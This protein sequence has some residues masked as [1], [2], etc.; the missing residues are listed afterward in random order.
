[1][2]RDEATAK[3]RKLLQTKGRTNAEA[4]TAQILAAA[5]AEKHNIDI[6]A[7]D[8]ADEK[9]RIEITHRSVGEWAKEP[10]EATYAASICQRFF[11]VHAHSRCGWTET[12]IFVGSPWH[13]D[14]AEYVFNFLIKEFRWQWNKKRGRCRNRKQFIY[15]CFVALFVKL[16]ERFKTAGQDGIEISWAA[17][18]E[19]YVADNF[20]ELSHSKIAPRDKGGVATSRGF[21][22]GQDIEIRQGVQSPNTAPAQQ[23]GFESRLLTNGQ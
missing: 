17:K 22:A 6:S 11:E 10:P 3:I 20:G 8:V 7:I 16:E 18:R 15:G 12:K 9:A 19:K 5:I 21:R 4:D 1:M 14:V 13:L 2:T 23:L